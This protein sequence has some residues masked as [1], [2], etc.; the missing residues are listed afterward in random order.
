MWQMRR[1]TKGPVLILSCDPNELQRCWLNDYAPEMIAVEAR[2]YPKLETLAEYLGGNVEIL[3][4]EIS[5]ITY[6]D[7]LSLLLLNGYTAVETGN[8]VSVVPVTSVRA[9]PIPLV[10]GKDSFPDA[11]FVTAVVPVRSLAKMVRCE[12][13]TVSVPVGNVTIGSK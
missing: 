2:R 13:V 3:G 8:Y 9:E 6:G 4:Q 11:Q 10:S 7:L 12:P 1:V 5:S